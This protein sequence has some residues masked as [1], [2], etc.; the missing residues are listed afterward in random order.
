[1]FDGGEVYLPLADLI[2]LGQEI[3]RLEGEQ[4]NLE[5]ELGRV[6]AKLANA[7]FTDRAPAKVV[8]AERDKLSR[9][10]DMYSGVT[11]R[12][13]LLREEQNRV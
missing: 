7:A 3:V 9:Y 4:V 2:D 10:E 12:L 13:Q 8:Q 5:Q 6:R 1:L 11:A